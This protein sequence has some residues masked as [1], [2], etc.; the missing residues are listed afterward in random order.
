MHVSAKLVLL[1]RSSVTPHAR[2]IAT[3]DQMNF[4]SPD[5]WDFSIY[6]FDLQNFWYSKTNLPVFRGCEIV[7]YDFR[8]KVRFRAGLKN[9]S[10]QINFIDS[11]SK[12]ESRLQGIQKID[13]IMMITI[14]GYDWDGVSDVG[15]LG[16]EINFDEETTNKIISDEHLYHLGHMA[17]LFGSK[18]AIVTRP[19][20]AA[21]ALRQMACRHLST[22]DQNHSLNYNNTELINIDDSLDITQTYESESIINEDAFIEIAKNII[23]ETVYEPPQIN[24]FSNMS[25]RNVALTIERLLWQPPDSRQSDDD[26]S[27]EEFAALLKVS[28]RTIQI[29]IQEQFGVGFIALRRLIRLHQIRMA[30]RSGNGNKKINVLG[31]TYYMDHLSRLSTEY[32]QLFGLLPSHERNIKSKI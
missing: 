16:I 27:L 22:L 25:R 13:S 32:K 4:Q 28:R 26:Y 31:R 19:S 10:L 1:W 15:A 11:Y 6:S 30:I 12:K 8:G 23:D 7:R 21:M 2:F 14:G 17:N 5:A 3:D 29:A 9:K 18:R 20:A 24:G